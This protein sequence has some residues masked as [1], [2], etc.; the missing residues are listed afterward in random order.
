MKKTHLLFII[1]AGILSFA[2]SFLVSWYMKKNQPVLPEDPSASQTD[3]DGQIAKPGSLPLPRSLHA[4]EAD[5]MDLGLSE[6]QL[7][8]LIQD[9]RDRM[10]EYQNKEKQLTKEAER[11]EL[12]HQS[13]QEEIDRLNQLRNKLSVLT[14]SLDD[15]EQQLKKSLLQ[16][17]KV[18]QDNFKRLAATYDKM[19]TTQASRI[20]SN[21]AS[22]PQYSDAIKILYYMSERTSAKVLGEI[23]SNQ[24]EL[25]AMISMKLK[26]V[27]ESG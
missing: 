25:A 12:A 27:Q 11:I 8:N 1:I 23:G 21:M 18:E 14:Q 22:G 3:P 26:R 9:I 20:L 13:L 4:A 2:S 7:Q 10:Q 19:D 15:K 5:S 17:E 16:I 6:R 24:P